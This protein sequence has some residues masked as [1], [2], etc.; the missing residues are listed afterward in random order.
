MTN[1]KKYGG[2]TIFYPSGVIMSTI[3]CKDDKKHGFFRKYLED[4][5]LFFEAE[6][7]LDSLV[8]AMR[9]H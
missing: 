4:G 9:L 5:S 8:S 6:F 2:D 1:G 3:E 7:A